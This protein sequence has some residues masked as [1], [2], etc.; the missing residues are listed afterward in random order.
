MTPVGASGDAGARHAKA[1]GDGVSDAELRVTGGRRR[2]DA[3]GCARCGSGKRRRRRMSRCDAAIPARGF[4]RNATRATRATATALVI[5]PSASAPAE[6]S[7]RHTFESNASRPSLATPCDT[8]PCAV[9]I[10]SPASP[11]IP[12]AARPRSGRLTAI[13][14]PCFASVPALS[15]SGI[16]GP[17]TDQGTPPDAPRRT[18]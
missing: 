13:T 1:A 8:P 9:S 15:L 6:H 3:I 7:L 12:V 17:N 4:S 10:A 11:R 2:R 5:R 14:T 16:P 18:S